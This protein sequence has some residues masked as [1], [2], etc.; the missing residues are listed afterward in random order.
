MKTTFFFISITLLIIISCGTS[1]NAPTEAQI[2][3]LDTLIQKRQFRI[4]SNFAYPQNTTALQSVLNS[5]IL[6]PGSSSG[7]ISLIGNYNYLKISGDS[8]SS[9]LPYFGERQMMVNYGGTDGAITFNGLYEDYSIL[10]NKNN[11]YSIQLIAKSNNESFNVF[12][13]ITP[14]LKADM[15]LSGTG[16]FPIQYSGTVDFYRK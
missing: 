15:T 11:S 4:E 5:G 12:I 2:K 10:K 3:A 1:K 6:Q 16:R 9:H 13:T 7:A 8:I 14:N